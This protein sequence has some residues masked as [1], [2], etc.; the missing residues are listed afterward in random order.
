MQLLLDGLLPISVSGSLRDEVATA[1][2]SKCTREGKHFR[3][4]GKY[5]T[6]LELKFGLTC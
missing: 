5:L 2:T 1:S 6:L 3:V 4:N